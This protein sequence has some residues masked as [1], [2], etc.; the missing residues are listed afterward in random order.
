LILQ[1][2]HNFVLLRQVVGAIDM[3]SRMDWIICQ[4]RSCAL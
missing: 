3:P 4:K 1:T 2:F